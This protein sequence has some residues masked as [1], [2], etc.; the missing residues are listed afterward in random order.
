M[1][2]SC[3]IAIRRTDGPHQTGSMSNARCN[4]PTL[5]GGHCR[6]PRAECPHHRATP[7]PGEPTRAAA[8]DDSMAPPAPAVER[9]PER[10]LREL[11]WWMVDE[12]L[13]NRVGRE[14]AS[15]VAAIMRVLAGLGAD[16]AHDDEALAEIELRGRLAHG[17]P[18]RGDEQWALARQRFTDAALRE[19][20]RWPGDGSGGDAD[21]PPAGPDGDADEQVST[22][23]H[24]EA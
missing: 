8:T 3:R 11:G 22:F 23:A 19:F 1:S 21:T 7:T 6:W 10:D 17:M 16:D 24:G 9:P 15:G 4:E 20:E 2:R 13:A 18:P 12:V 5:A 14:Q